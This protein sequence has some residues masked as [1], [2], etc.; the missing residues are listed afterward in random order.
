MVEKRKLEIGLLALLHSVQ[1]I[2]LYAL[3]P[4]YTI[5]RL[6]FDI[7]IFQIGLLGSVY[8]VVSVFQGPAGYLVER[9]GSKHLSVF[10][11][12]GCSAAVF[13]YSLAPNFN[14]LL[15]AA[16]LFALSQVV[17][18]PVTYAMVTE[19]S[20]SSNKA[21]YIAYHRARTCINFLFNLV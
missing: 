13:M 14:F 6:E 19:R 7:S 11:M 4:L 2:Y 9:I 3:P 16:T 15:L 10:S 17:F 18:H 12:L 5:L 1:H 8:G 21:R 20:S